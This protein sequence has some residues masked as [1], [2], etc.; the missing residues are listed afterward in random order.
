[1]G[2]GAVDVMQRLAVADYVDCGG[3]GLCCWVVSF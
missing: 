2:I 1:M 3:G